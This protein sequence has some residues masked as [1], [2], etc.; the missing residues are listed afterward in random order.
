[1]SDHP[2]VSVGIPTYN[3]PA[4]L[5]RTLDCIT[6]QTYANLEILVSDNCSPSGETEEVVRA[7]QRHDPRVRYFRQT[8]NIGLEANFKFVLEKASGPFFLWAADD[9]EWTPDFVAVCLAHSDGVGSVMTGMRSAVRTRG[10][11]RPKPPLDVSPERGCFAS[12]VAFFINLQPSLIHAL[13]RRE[14]L[15]LFL[16]ERMFDYYDCFFI[17]RQVLTHGFRVVPPVCFYVGVDTEAQVFKPARPRS[18]AIYE[19]WPFLSC[20]VREV[21]RCPGLSLLQ[22]ARLTYLL[23]YVVLNEFAYFEQSARPRKA[24]L[25]RLGMGLLRPLRH[26]FRVGLPKPPPVMTMPADPAEVGY[27]FLPAAELSTEEGVRKHLDD[28]RA[29]LRAKEIAIEGLKAETDRLARWARAPGRT[30]SALRR[31]VWRRTARPTAA[32]PPESSSSLEGLRRELGLV[33]LGMEDRQARIMALVRKLARYRRL[34]VLASAVR[35]FP[36]TILRKARSILRRWRRPAAAS[37]TD[38]ARKAA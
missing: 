33:L 35:A 23:T 32:V 16:R 27:M 29:Q 18:G 4:G 19:Y 31:L 12:A 25:A 34:A 1:M 8:E 5:R 37:E 9:D 15:Q 3:R 13:H 36:R 22:K 6:R 24:R 2:L 7:F 26:V 21:V 17:L 11:L 28:C 30:L 10:L 38:P 20:S 14:T